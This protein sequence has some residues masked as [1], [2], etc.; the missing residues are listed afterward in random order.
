MIAVR[1]EHRERAIIVGIVTGDVRREQ[2]EEYLDELT[3]L[4]DTAG[5]DVVH[6]IVQERVGIDPVYYIGKG[7]VEQ[8]VAVV[9]DEEISLV[10]FDDDLSPAQMKN[11]AGKIGCKILDRSGV[12]LDIFAKRARTSE[13][14]TQVELAQ[15]EYLLPRLTRAWTH[16]SKQYGG[17]GTKGPGETQ[18][19]TDRRMVRHRI[20]HLKEKLG[21]ITRQRAT[22]RGRRKKFATA[23]LV[24]Y[25]NAGKSTLMN[26]L[27][28][29]DV[30]VENRLFATLDTTTRKATLGPGSALLLS[31]TVGFIRKLPTHLIASF[32]STLE[33]VVEA[34]LLVHVV[35]VSHPQ[36]ED[37]IEVVK[38]TLDELGAGDKPVLYVFNK[39]D[40]LA[41]RA[42]LQQLASRFSPSI[43]IS[44]ERGINLLGLRDTLRE[45]LHAAQDEIAYVISY[46][47]QGVIGQLHSIADVVSTTYEEA[48]IVVYIKVDARNKNRV[49][50]LLKK[51]GAKTVRKR[52]QGRRSQ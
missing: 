28:D 27:A 31:D 30:F 14:R 32:K 1:K 45:L 34:D 42:F 24:G 21:R 17:I 36:F 6:R 20:S 43:A 25:T 9:E 13:A 29:A 11:L 35:D 51:A 15:L 10:L 5:A 48:H 16:L 8:I 41:D 38:K 7:K 2:A 3:L 40:L 44:A 46:E 39:T 50:A 52:K 49:E 19:E 4:A 26:A 22:Q 12:I 37:Q 33:E 23:S 47:S 18:I